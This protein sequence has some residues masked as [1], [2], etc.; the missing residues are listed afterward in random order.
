MT[1]Q[2]DNYYQQTNQMQDHYQR[3]A[4]KYNNLWSYSQDFIEFISQNIV[5][6]LN[7]KSTDT[8][9]DI[10]CGTGI[11]TQATTDLAQLINPVTCVDLSE[12]MLEQLPSNGKYQT[13][14][15]DAF[16]FAD[17]P[18]EYDKIL[19]KEMIHHIDD[20]EKLIKSLF[21]RLLP[22]GILLL[23]LLPPTIDYPLFNAAKKRHQELQPH[24]GELTEIFEKVGFKTTVEFVEYLVSIEKYRYLKMIENRYMS[25]LSTFTNEEIE[26]GLDELKNKYSQ[27]SMLQFNDRFVFIIGKKTA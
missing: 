10:G 15:M 12:K 19:I 2:T 22:G 18:G 11:F 1:K 16:S 3:L 6:Y 8:F 13:V 23:I 7:L 24:Y 4:E 20:R 25:L 9:A 27:R 21:A 14:A 17:R 5:R 26:R